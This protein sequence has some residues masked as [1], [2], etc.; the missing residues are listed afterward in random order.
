MINF[1]NILLGGPLFCSSALSERGSALGQTPRRL[2]S[3]RAARNREAAAAAP[4]VV[5]LRPQ[6]AGGR[7]G[8]AARQLGSDG[9]PFGLSE[10]GSVGSSRKKKSKIT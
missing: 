8:E 2:G 9:R 5:V 1:T 10:L 6:P 4:S 7:P 3:F